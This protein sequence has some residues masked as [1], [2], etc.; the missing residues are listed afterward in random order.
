MDN[1]KGHFGVDYYFEDHPGLRHRWFYFVDTRA[2]L[3]W[4]AERGTRE[5]SV[6]LDRV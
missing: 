1:K 3:D 5:A 2:C 4:W 6:K